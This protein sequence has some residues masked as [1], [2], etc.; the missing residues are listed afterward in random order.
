MSRLELLLFGGERWALASHWV[1][2]V[3]PLE[4]STNSD[5][6]DLSEW[7][8][9]NTSE[10][11][12]PHRLRMRAL[13]QAISL[14]VYGVLTPRVFNSDEVLDLPKDIFPRAPVSGLV[15]LGDNKPPALLID[16]M[17]FTERRS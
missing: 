2:Q 14:L 8:I 6:R 7:D 15:L 3:E 10:S 11:G 4:N 16:P 5:T 12:T 13:G 17:R 9:D 1:A